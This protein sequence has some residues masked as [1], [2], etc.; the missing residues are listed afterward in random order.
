[1]A[2]V[3]TIQVPRTDPHDGALVFDV[4]VAGPPEGD[5]VVLLHGFPQTGL[6]YRGVIG[7][8]ADAGY[9]V[10]VP[11]QR[12]YSPGARPLAVEAYAT[13]RLVDDVVALADWAGEERFHLVGHDWGAVVAW[14]AAA[15]H[16][17]RLRSLTALSVPHP[18]AFADAVFG[19]A[20]DGDQAGRSSY[21]AIF[22]EEGT[23]HGMLANDATGLRMLYA[24]SGLTAEE[25][26]PYL[27]ALSTPEALGAALNWYRAGDLTMVAMDDIEVPTLYVWSTNDVALGRAGA[28]ATERYV[29]GPYRFVV[30]DG[31]DHWIPEHATDRLVDELLAWYAA[32]P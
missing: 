5:L 14:R 22:R 12:G 26:E 30:L 19:D 27:T 1:M 8:L 13:E 2:D 32:H 31:V 7:P 24:A 18:R 9:R 10:L 20:A 15:D 6:A 11:D 29:S 25:S 21:V 3:T 23:E 16:A 17:E 28:E 4:A